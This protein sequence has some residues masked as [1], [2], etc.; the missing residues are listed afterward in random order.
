MSFNSRSAP[1]KKRPA[2]ESLSAPPAKRS[3]SVDQKE[4]YRASIKQTYHSFQV[5]SSDEPQTGEHRLQAFEQLLSALSGD[6][7]S[8]RLAVK[9]VPRFASTFPSKLEATASSLSA[10][11]TVNLNSPNARAS[12]EL[13]LAAVEALGSI[14]SACCQCLE[15]VQQ[16]ERIT[17]LLLWHL[18][19]R[20]MTDMQQT[21]S[22]SPSDAGR[23][24]EVAAL[25]RV[26]LAAMV[27]HP[28]HAVPGAVSAISSP[29][30]GIAHAARAFLESIVLP[31]VLQDAQHL[32]GSVK[33]HGVLSS[34]PA[35]S[36]SPSSFQQCLRSSLKS[37]YQELSPIKGREAKLVMGQLIQKLP[38]AFEPSS[39]AAPGSGCLPPQRPHASHQS[40][41][42]R[43]LP[44]SSA[45]RQPSLPGPVSPDPLQAF[46]SAL[47][48]VIASPVPQQIPQDPRNWQPV[49]HRQAQRSPSVGRKRS[50]S[51]GAPHQQPVKSGLHDDTVGLEAPEFRP[52]G[53][54]CRASR[55]LW[56]G[57]LHP[58]VP[59]SE[60]RQE[61]MRFGNVVGITF[62]PCPLHDEAQVTFSNI[63]EAALCYEAMA[64][65]APWGVRPLDVRF[66][67]QILPEGMTD[68][69]WDEDSRQNIWVANATQTEL[70]AIL[71]GAGLP[72]PQRVLPVAGLKPGFVLN[73]ESASL[74]QPTVNAVQP[75]FGPQAAGRRHSASPP[76]A[77]PANSGSDFA[78]RTLWVG[79][80][81][82][83]VNEK[84]LL[85]AFRRYG[86]VTGHSMIRKSNCAFVDF[87][88]AAAATEAKQAL[89]GARFSSCQI[90]LEYKDEPRGPR[91]S[92]REPR[93]PSRDFGRMPQR[94][95]MPL[96]AADSQSWGR[97]PFREGPPLHRGG[98]S[99]RDGPHARPPSPP[100]RPHHRHP[101]PHRRPWD[102]PS[103]S[104]PSHRPMLGASA[105][106]PAASPQPTVSCLQAPANRLASA[107]GQDSLLHG[108]PG[109][110]SAIA[111]PPPPLPQDHPP[112]EEP[113]DRDPQLPP[114]P[115]EPPSP[116]PKP[117][118]EPPPPVA[119]NP[120][121]AVANHHGAQQ[122][123]EA[124]LPASTPMPL[125]APPLP[126]ASASASQPTAHSR[127]VSADSSDRISPNFPA[128][129]VEGKANGWSGKA[130]PKHAEPEP[131][132]P[133]AD[134]GLLSGLP[135]GFT[136]PRKSLSNPGSGPAS[137]ASNSTRWTGHLA[138]SG[139]LIC[140]ILCMD[141]HQH[142]SSVRPAMTIEPAEWPKQLDVDNRID[143]PSVYTSFDRA[144]AEQRAV[145]K[146]ALPPAATSPSHEALLQHQQQRRAFVEFLNYL[147]G[148]RRAG[149]V[150]LR[151]SSGS[152]GGQPR[153]LY[154]IPA[155]ASV[156]ERFKL[157]WEPTELLVAVVV[158]K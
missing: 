14:L 16:A 10:L 92:F 33:P 8:K 79:Q 111:S 158:P 44:D 87:E 98:F 110:R 9:L 63:H 84:E 105:S 116:I 119:A 122:R 104:P 48:P 125:E 37:A 120:N 126:A 12:Q 143:V 38:A 21:S 65:M 26:L 100:F 54:V 25:Q 69:G 5:L 2:E 123:A 148:K 61:C 24:N 53:P 147:S 58:S 139:K 77:A 137:A 45:R 115:P 150:Q 47:K 19:A 156:I 102:D 13:R 56:I 68:A 27:L 141:P 3:S 22:F 66:C 7:P 59:E 153:I 140:P 157:V 94:G 93:S 138:K 43:L 114:L 31:L 136:R 82:P 127:P 32:N 50:R 17:C 135:P 55:C 52:G 152:M 112:K 106:L 88:S 95:S 15:T 41:D 124:P 134:S 103:T 107:A 42:N 64:D 144:H 130:S 62:P 71:Q 72:G 90:R 131:T 57:S 11:A 6:L 40:P 49:A 74:V 78:G 18:Q 99:R 73:L 30:A 67:E 70:L 76:K 154:L 46:E 118:T 101:V 35:D 132:L 97:P 149:V 145:R 96:P 146:L 155:S 1:H 91:G 85:A 117:P 86:R 20:A 80:L 4:A 28:Q 128:A 36:F 60:L 142:S 23:G 109:R 75:H 133:T 34:I 39:N 121:G 51:P 81:G 83:D 151:P 89:N 108:Q 29:D 129:P 113:E